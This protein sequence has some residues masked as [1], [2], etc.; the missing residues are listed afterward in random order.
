[1]ILANFEHPRKQSFLIVWTDPGM[2]ICVIEEH[3]V[4]TLLPIHVTEEGIVIEVS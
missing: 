4:N 2:T 3:L 1:M